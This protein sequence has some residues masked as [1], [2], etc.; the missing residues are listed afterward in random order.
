MQNPLENFLLNLAE[1]IQT[2]M[3]YK[4][5]VKNS[6]SVDVNKDVFAG[7]I[8][9]IANTIKENVKN[10]PTEEKPSEPDPLENFLS[11]L[12]E[13]LKNLP[14]KKKEEEPIKQEE[15]VKENE[16]VKQEEPVEEPKPVETKPENE[17]IKS[18]ENETPDAFAGF[19]NNL[20]NILKKT[21][22]QKI[23]QPVENEK[24][25]EQVNDYV[26][27]LSN[28]KKVKTPEIKNVEKK[29]EEN[30]ETPDIKKF[31]ANFVTKELE[32]FKNDLTEKYLKKAA[33]LSEYAGG[34]GTNA[35]QYANG[36][37]MNG[38]LN[39]NGNYLSGGVNLLNIFS[40]GGGGGGNQTLSFNPS[41]ADLSISGGNTVSLS[42]LSGGGLTDR[43]VSGSV[44]AILANIGGGNGTLTL[45]NNNKLYTNNLG[46][47][48]SA[49]P[50]G[51]AELASNNTSNFVWVDDDGAYVTTDALTGFKL[52]HFDANGDLIFPTDSKISKGY[53]GEIQD[54]SSW[55]VSPTGQV[56]GLASAD[57]QQYVQVGDNSN[58][59]I[60]TGWPD[61]LHEWIFR[62]D[63]KLT[64]PG[65]IG[66]TTG[67]SK[68]DLVGLGPNIAYLTST[69]D[70]TTALY[71]A[72]DVA[73]LR[74]NTTVSIYTNT[75]A[76]SR[77]WTFGTDGSLSFPDNT[78]QTTAFTGNPDL[79]PYAKITDFVH[80]SGDTMTGDLYTPTLSAG[81]IYGSG[82]LKIGTGSDIN[83]V[84]AYG[85]FTSPMGI[86]AGFTIHRGD[87]SS[88]ASLDFLENGLISTGWSIQMQPSNSDLQFVDRVNSSNAFTIQA[89]GNVG[90]GTTTPAEKLTIAGNIKA[91]GQFSF[92]N[93]DYISSTDGT[94]NFVDLRNAN[95]YQLNF[96]N[97]SDNGAGDWHVGNYIPWGSF[98]WYSTA[99]GRSMLDLIDGTQTETGHDLGVYFYDNVSINAGAPLAKLHVKGSSDD[100]NTPIAIIESDGSQ[101]PYTFRV[102]GVD[103]AYV[104]GDD[105]GNLAFGAQNF[106]AF[107][108][109]GFGD[110]AE[111]M[112][113]TVDKNVGI[114]TVIPS[115]KLEVVG[116]LKVRNGNAGL[117]FNQG[118]G[119]SA[120]I[121]FY[122]S[123]IFNGG[124]RFEFGVAGNPDIQF[125]N[126]ENGF[127]RIGTDN[128][129]RFRITSDGNV[130]IGTTAPS[131]KLEVNGNVKA[132]GGDSTQW[133][134]NYT[135]VSEN[136]AY[137]ADTRG[138]V[139]FGQNVTING[140][141]TALGFS[142]FRNTIFTTTSALSVV[143]NGPGP[144][145]YV[146]QSP[147][148]FDVASFYDQDGIE[149]LHI[150]NAPTPGTL[151]KVG[152]NESYPGAELTV[153]GA[154]SSNST[155]T[156]KGGNSNDWN[157]NY[158]TTNA[159]SSKW[160]EAY[161]NL[162]SN[163]AA[164]LSAV[165][166]SLL[167]ATSGSWNSVYTTVNTNSATTWNYQ[168]TDI[169][170][171][172]AGWVGGNSAYTTTNSN[173]AFWANAY[174]NLV[175][176]SAAYLL[177]GTDV[178]LGQIPV[179]SAN[180]NSVYSTTNVNS[181]F[182]SQAYTNLVTNS[183]TYLGTTRQF[184]IVQVGLNSYSYCG[185]AVPGTSTA[186][187][188][189]TIKRLFFSTAGTLLSSG[190]VTNS[191]WN[192]RYSYNY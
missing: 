71:M 134:S 126:F 35:V 124:A 77:L 180:W 46:I 171:L 52:W 190:T 23:E 94:G 152:I 6:E 166:I 130:G 22:E 117:N 8:E 96:V 132:T 141:L 29:P 123:T 177:S 55:F 162:T 181:A 75:G 158:T 78:T 36:G 92:Q 148:N 48:L 111:A 15:P 76:T 81:N 168:G 50:G 109:G 70:D 122:N 101:A 38:D 189:W 159:N 138:D 146:S 97:T 164:Y 43:L 68:L 179:L 49:G 14:E 41:N 18:E 161:T 61:S 66:T 125:W 1:K 119:N 26:K 9:G 25:K 31:V 107:E 167:A 19:V 118:T 98:S 137:W 65:A 187:T 149:V 20:A 16:P 156:A 172:T 131:E 100:V 30:E 127:F 108:A 2:E 165:D 120:I 147:G 7:F 185:F 73:E 110:A 188:G 5:I 45:P 69:A 170:N 11:T 37:T 67:N 128:T 51:F 143:N 24:P 112:R 89:G 182:W 104:K 40:G 113:I 72:T 150:G 121:D 178:N 186:S 42:A 85:L 4:E 91:D 103:R 74:A 10:E 59:Y 80:L 192:S 157:S 93:G 62:T 139:T 99:L 64:V 13:K 102:G 63:G 90:I 154:I 47:D 87:D 44:Q 184:D 151:A 54:G 176:N 114:G 86:N 95:Y 163:S 115:E 57:G 145:L 175:T 135:T 27:V 160:S 144:A 84:G 173:S 83:V 169:K 12:G 153:N 21:P 58:V 183:A 88:Y 105:G 32:S 3:E 34:G 140:N 60:G 155:I 79:T 28:N 129:E 174:T 39:V 17:P 53:P 136:S 33:V 106:I 133:N 191:I 116:N 56:G 82:L 142:I